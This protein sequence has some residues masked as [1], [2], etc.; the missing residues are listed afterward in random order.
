M[1][2]GIVSWQIG[3]M[4]S[5]ESR[6]DLFWAQL[7]IVSSLHSTLIFEKQL[8]ERNWTICQY[9]YIFKQ[10]VYINDIDRGITNWILKFADD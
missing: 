8:T 9:N 3:R 5:V 10:L 4:Y 7:N 6:K 2:T 1:D